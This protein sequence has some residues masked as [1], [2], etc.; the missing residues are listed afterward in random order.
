MALR[1]YK[2]EK[3]REILPYLNNIVGKHLPRIVQHA[4]STD[5]HCMDGSEWLKYNIDS[6][7]Q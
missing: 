5:I 4:I 6:L 1:P 2:L 3:I 7:A